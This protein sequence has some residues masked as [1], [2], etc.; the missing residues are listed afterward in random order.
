[1]QDI[2]NQSPPGRKQQELINP[3]FREELKLI[4]KNHS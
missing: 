2:A 4:E 3:A 1:M